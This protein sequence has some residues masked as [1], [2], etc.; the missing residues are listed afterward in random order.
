VL[1]DLLNGLVCHKN[2]ACF[3]GKWGE[4]HFSLIRLKMVCSSR[5]TG[6]IGSKLQWD[7]MLLV[8]K[9][10]ASKGGSRVKFSI[11]IIVVGGLDLI[12]FV[13]R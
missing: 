5:I 4:S 3:A 9:K 13:L 1:F 8:Q 10:F 11:L 6:A 12:V 2:I 7:L